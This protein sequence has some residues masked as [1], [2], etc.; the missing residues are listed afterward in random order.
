MV[1]FFAVV[2]AGLELPSDFFSTSEDVFMVAM[3]DQQSVDELCAHQG[4]LPVK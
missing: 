3:T 2:R 4:L 1:N